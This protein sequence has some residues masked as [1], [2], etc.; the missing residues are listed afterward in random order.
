MDPE[1]KDA[2]SVKS[3]VVELMKEH[4][5]RGEFDSPSLKP[6]RAG[7]YNFKD[8]RIEVSC[9]PSGRD[10]WLNCAVSVSLIRGRWPRRKLEAVL[11][12]GFGAEVSLFRPG[13]WIDYVADMAE[14]ARELQLARDKEQ[15]PRVEAEA[16]RD[17]DARFGPVD[18]SSIF[19]K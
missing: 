4:V 3:L 14:R 8:Q 7:A 1:I 10:G 13:N 9:A 19:K 11:H 17:H 15:Q 16:V 2:L 18:D 12:T 5:F 6:D